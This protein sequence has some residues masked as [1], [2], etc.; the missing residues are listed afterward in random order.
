MF[1][2]L[3]HH[4]SR[5]PRGV[6]SA[7]ASAML[8]RW[9]LGLLMTAPLAAEPQGIEVRGTTVAF[10][11]QV[12]LADVEVAIPSLSL[13]TRSDA[14]GGFRFP[15][16]PPGTH[17][18][19]A[20]RLGYQA[21]ETDIR[22]GS[23]GPSL[24]R[25]VLLPLQRLDSVEVVATPLDNALLQFEEHRRVGLGKFVTRAELAKLE[26]LRTVSAVRPLSGVQVF[27]NSNNSFIN[28]KRAPKPEDCLPPARGPQEV[29]S[30]LPLTT[31]QIFY[32][33]DLAER[34][35]GIACVCY[36]QVYLDDQLMNPGKPTPPFDINQIP[37]A[38]IE[39]IEWYSGPSQTPVQY[40]RLNSACG[41]LVIHRRRNP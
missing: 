21:F 10:R 32:D 1:T 11:S 12:P 40:T 30:R 22:V 6:R 4:L 15:R 27:G 38:G 34:R 36:A 29:V 13:S 26:G 39:A 23:A 28:S 25:V 14:A 7:R 16:V 5:P 35:Q 3:R 33:P 19:T 41:V 31:G 17:K 20:R 37:V 9:V 2:R 18:L 8:R 24:V